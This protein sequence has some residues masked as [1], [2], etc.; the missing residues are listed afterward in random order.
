MGKYTLRYGYRKN[1]R[2]PFGLLI[3]VTAIGVFSI[4]GA[5]KPA[6]DPVTDAVVSKVVPTVEAEESTDLK[7]E[8]PL[9]WPVYGQSAYGVVKDGVLA[10]SEDNAQKVPIASLA[11]TITALAILE[12]KPLKPGEQGPMITFTD[13]DVALYRDYLAKDGTVVPVVAGEQISQYQA[14]QAMLLPSANNISDTAAIWAFGSMD[15]Y[16]AYANHLIKE[17][18]ITNTYIADASGYSPDTVSTAADMVKIGI[19]YMQ[20]PI[21]REIASQQSAILPVAGT[22]A[23]Y[24]SAYN[25]NG[26]IGIK[27]GYTEQAGRTFLVAD[28]QG[29]NKD[30][31]SVAAVL[32]ANSMPEAMK[33]AERILRSGNGEHDKLPKL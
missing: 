9:A 16:V 4:T 2:W 11:K 1:R 10:Q 12:R 20:N 5:K 30:Q 28:V 32:G 15:E 27:V 26:I 33:D 19:L 17:Y 7:I 8:A 23:N 31:I 24:N 25:G 3:V 14:L 22:V 13:A 6:D 18:G 21:L 29:S